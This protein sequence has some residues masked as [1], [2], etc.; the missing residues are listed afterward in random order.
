MLVVPYLLAACLIPVTQG[1]EWD[2]SRF[3]WYSGESGED[4]K[5]AIPIGNGRLGATVFGNSIERVVLNENSVWSGPWEDRVNPK[6]KG[7]LAS[8]RGMLVAGNITA[9]GQSAMSN[10]AGEPTSPK[11]YQP[12]VNLTMDFGHTTTGISSYSRWLDTLQGTSGVN[13]SYGGVN[14]RYHI[15]FEALIMRRH[16][17]TLW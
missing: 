16:T 14:Y 3:A 13:Y 7:A 1:A 9:A 4:F 17:L 15:S 6:A 8:I 5:R 12:L 2:G 11:A 10:L